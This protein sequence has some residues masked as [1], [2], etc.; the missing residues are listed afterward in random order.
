M[1][2]TL[3]EI[4]QDAKVT[5]NGYLGLNSV[6]NSSK[7]SVMDAIIW[8]SSSCI[9]A[10]ENLMDVLKVD[11]AQDLNNRINGTP[12]YF[13]NALLKYQSGDELVISEDGTKFSYASID[14][15]KNIIKKVAY[16]E[17]DEAGFHDKISVFKIATEVDGEFQRIDADEMVK[18]KA[19]LQN[20]L[21]AGQHAVIYSRKGDVIVPRVTVYY[22]GA[23][24]EDE[25]YANLEESL[26]E[27]I[28][29]TDFNGKIYH[30][31]IIDTLQTA[32][33]VVDVHIDNTSTDHQGI[34]FAQFDDADNII[35]QGE[36]GL[37]K[38]DR[39]FVPSSG[40]VR[41]STGMGD[42]AGLPRFRNAITLKIENTGNE[43]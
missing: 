2:R 42:E 43:V 34:Y 37:V 8:T 24:T 41:E 7:M 39:Y 36:G 22:D 11:L 15:S 5:V 23:V 1:A 3:S 32:E 16:E 21:F 20:I 13:A 40:Y 26:R 33:H 27:F 12:G 28:A 4:Y 31:K 10:F 25:V 38:M 17:L 19:Y 30:Q 6:Q 35:D 18:I 29:Q 9:W 14:E